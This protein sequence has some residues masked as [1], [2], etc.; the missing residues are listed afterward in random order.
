MNLIEN[1][2]KKVVDP[3]CVGGLCSKYIG[4]SSACPVG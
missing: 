4:F 2:I 1:K 3:G